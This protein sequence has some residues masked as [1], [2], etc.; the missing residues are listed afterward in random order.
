MSKTPDK[1]V[2]D[3]TPKTREDKLKEALKANLKR[4]KAQARA[5][6]GTAKT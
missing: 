6:K 3:K 4:R 1:S 2:R 5:R